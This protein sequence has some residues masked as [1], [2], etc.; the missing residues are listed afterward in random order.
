MSWAQL[1]AIR[2][3]AMAQYELE[4]ATPP[5]ACPTDG[6]PLRIGPGGVRYCPY[7]GFRSDSQ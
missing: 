2:R 5:V 4:Q 7:D 6:E 3:E 1:V